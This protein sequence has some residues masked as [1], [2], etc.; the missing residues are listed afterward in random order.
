MSTKR[1]RE[2]SDQLELAIRTALS[3]PRIL[4]LEDGTVWKRVGLPQ[5]ESG[6]SVVAVKVPKGQGTIGTDKDHINVAVKDLVFAKYS[7]RLPAGYIVTR[8]NDPTNNAFGNLEES[9]TPY[10]YRRLRRVRDQLTFDEEREVWRLYSKEVSK[11]NISKM[12]ST[13]IVVVEEILTNGKRENSG[14]AG[15]HHS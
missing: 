11:R 13:T 4:I 10:R 12:L 15:Y 9:D 14:E 8:D 5:R 6:G 2:I 1:K 3:D 7:G